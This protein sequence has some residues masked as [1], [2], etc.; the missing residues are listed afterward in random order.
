LNHQ[1]A[2]DKCASIIELVNMIGDITNIL[3]FELKNLELKD[4]QFH[5]LQGAYD[6]L[7]MQSTSEINDLEEKRRK[8]LFEVQQ[9]F[10]KKY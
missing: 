6:D 4:S 5:S 1:F 2:N 8:E 3:N 9:S 7:K 10:E